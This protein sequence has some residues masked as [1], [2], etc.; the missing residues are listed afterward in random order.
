MTF[1]SGLRVVMRKLRVW[2]ARMASGLDSVAGPDF[3]FALS[4]E[5][6]AERSIWPV[7]ECSAAA[8]VAS[9]RVQWA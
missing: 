9:G 3:H 5:L 8:G 6:S 7:D 1:V 4:M 2:P